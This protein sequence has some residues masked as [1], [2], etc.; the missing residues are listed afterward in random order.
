MNDHAYSQSAAFRS[1]LISAAAI[2]S[3]AT[4]SS[5]SPPPQPVPDG[6]GGRHGTLGCRSA[7]IPEFRS[8]SPQALNYVPSG[9]SKSNM[10]RTSASDRLMSKYLVTIPASQPY[11]PAN[12]LRAPRLAAGELPARGVDIVR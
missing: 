1:L 12:S 3:R 5:E 9:S 7:Q 8:P 10:A 2:T 6:P 4:S 11:V